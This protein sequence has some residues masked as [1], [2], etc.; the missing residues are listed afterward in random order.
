MALVGTEVVEGGGHVASVPE[1]DGVD[2]EPQGAELVLLALAVGLAQFAA[3]A[4]EDLA[5]QCVAGLA[6]VDLG[7]DAPA[8]GLV[9]E[10]GP[11]L[12]FVSPAAK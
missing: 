3:V 5:G 2:D 4:V 1:S 6:P 7:E 9:I 11:A 8:V 10:V 12:G